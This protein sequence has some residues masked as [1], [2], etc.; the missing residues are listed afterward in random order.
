MDGLGVD[1]QDHGDER[2]V[3]KVGHRGDEDHRED[4]CVGPYD[5]QVLEELGEVA[6]RVPSALACVPALAA[7]ARRALCPYARTS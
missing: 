2:D 7:G 4:E 1:G 3:Q 6:P 5:P